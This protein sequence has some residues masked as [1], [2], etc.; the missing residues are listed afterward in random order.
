MAL[1]RIAKTVGSFTSAVKS[2]PFHA[3]ERV[4]ARLTQVV[5]HPVCVFWCAAAGD[6]RVFTVAHWAADAWISYTAA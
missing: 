5:P 2:V 1:S 6:S 3:L 4:I